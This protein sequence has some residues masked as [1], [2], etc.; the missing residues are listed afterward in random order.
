MSYTRYYFNLFIFT[1]FLFRT[2]FGQTN[3]LPLYGTDANHPNGLFVQVVP[4]KLYSGPRQNPSSTYV[5][6]VGQGGQVLW[7]AMQGPNGV[8][9]QSVTS[10]VRNAMSA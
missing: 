9:G 1:M 5:V 7:D 8:S 3:C 4:K 10:A 2:C 6:T